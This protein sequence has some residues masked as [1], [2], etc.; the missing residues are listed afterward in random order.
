VFQAFPPN[1]K[2]VEVGVEPLAMQVEEAGVAK[3]AEAKEE[4]GG[5]AAANKL[6]L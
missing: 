5:K 1:K 3:A 6:H 4:A 2:P